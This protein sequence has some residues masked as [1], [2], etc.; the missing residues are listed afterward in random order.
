MLSLSPQTAVVCWAIISLAVYC[1]FAIHMLRSNQRKLWAWD[2]LAFVLYSLLEPYAVKSGLISLAPAALIAACLFTLATS[3]KPSNIH[4]IS[5]APRSISAANRLF[6]AAC[7]ISFLGAIVQHKP[8]QRVLLT[9]GLDFWAEVL[10]LIALFLWIGRSPLPES[11]SAPLLA[12]G[13]NAGSR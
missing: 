7:L 10:L 12:S 9:I 6:L 8:W 3:E 2:G 1:F 4:A 13:E 5:Q 11:I